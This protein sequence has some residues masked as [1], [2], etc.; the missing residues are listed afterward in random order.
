[1]SIYIYIYIMSY[2]SKN[3]S[4]KRFCDIY[5]SNSLFQDVPFYITLEDKV[6][7][8]EMLVITGKGRAGSDRFVI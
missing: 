2:L 1:M 8:G 7:P 6:K 5:V 4:L 3:K